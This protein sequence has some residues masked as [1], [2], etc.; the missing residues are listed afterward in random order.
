[1]PSSIYRLSPPTPS[2]PPRI[3]QSHVLPNRKCHSKISLA[4]KY[5]CPAVGRDGFGGEGEA[6]GS[7]IVPGPSCSL[8]PDPAQK[9]SSRCLDCE[10][11]GLTAV[12]REATWL[13]TPSWDSRRAPAS[14]A[15]LHRQG[16]TL[17]GPPAP[18]EGLF[19]IFLSW[20]LKRSVCFGAP[21]AAEQSS[22]LNGK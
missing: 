5:N 8:G 15:C 14:W 11:Q 17:A 3:K 20:S 21:A 4:L 22:P 19:V 18:G 7:G 1:M 12:P 6:G 10:V 9:V 13:A 2:P 16:R